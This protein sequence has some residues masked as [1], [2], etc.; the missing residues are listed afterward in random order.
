MKARL[1]YA[2]PYHDSDLAWTTRFFAADPYLAIRT[3]NKIIGVFNALE[4]QRARTESACNDVLLLNDVME[5]AKKTYGDGNIVNQIRVL[6]KQYRIKEFILG[7]TF[8][9]GVAKEM[10]SAKLCYTVAPESVLPEREVKS[11]EELAAIR[12]GNKAAEAGFRAVTDIL[13]AS[14]VKGGKVFYKGKTLTSET[15]HEAIA[16]AGLGLNAIS[17]HG[18][19]AAGGIQACDC[20]CHGH[21]PIYANELIV[22]DIFPRKQ[23]TGYYGDMTRTFLKGKANESQRALVAAVASAQKLALKN[24]KAGVTGISVH[25]KVA[26]FFE[27]KGYA[28]GVK[29]GAFTGFFHGLGHGLGLDVHEM[30]SL[31]LRGKKRLVAGNVLTVEPGLYYPGIGGCRIEDVVAVTKSGCEMLSRYPYTWE[32]R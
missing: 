19:I 31:S 9:V 28:T 18:I 15:L 2:N 20:H 6:A 8:P 12:E 17:D 16:V 14:T 21:G 27:S 1:F 30:P 13:K 4:I 24:I 3:K 11:R 22:V 32:I 25:E 29:Q 26:A 5:A 23:K 10:E 7:S